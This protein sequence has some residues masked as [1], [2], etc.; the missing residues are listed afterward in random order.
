MT[1]YLVGG[2]EL[3]RPFRVRRIGHIGYHSPDVDATA[4]FLAKALGLQQSDVDDFTS[5]VP[6][7]SKKDATGY[8]FRCGTDHHTV[9]IG[10]QALVDTRE[11]AR[12][13]ALVG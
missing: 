12:R 11:P 7:L 10:S 3:P 9:V 5:R 4:Q 6:Q 2:L 1:Q 8:F 13:G